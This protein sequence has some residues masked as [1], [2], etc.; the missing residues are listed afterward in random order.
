[1]SNVSWWNGTACTSNG[2]SNGSI[3]FTAS[4]TTDTSMFLFDDYLNWH[5]YKEEKYYPAYHL[6]KSYGITK[7]QI[8]YIRKI[9]RSISQLMI[10]K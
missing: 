2:T 9:F 3:T 5:P 4:T 6:L 1:M 7:K 8:S 10:W